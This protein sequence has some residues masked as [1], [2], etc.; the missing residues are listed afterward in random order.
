MGWHHQLV[1][2]LKQK[3]L[4]KITEYH[5]PFLPSSL[6]F[7]TS[8][9]TTWRV[10]PPSRK[11]CSSLLA[12]PGGPSIQVLSCDSNF[13]IGD[14]ECEVLGTRR[15]FGPGKAPEN[16]LDVKKTW[17][18]HTFIAISR[19]LWQNMTTW[20]SHIQPPVGP[21]PQGFAI[22]GSS[23]RPVRNRTGDG[24]RIYDYYDT[25]G[26]R[27]HRDGYVL[28][29]G[30]Q[31]PWRSVI[32]YVGDPTTKL[33]QPSLKQH[34]PWKSQWLESDLFWG[35]KALFFPRSASVKQT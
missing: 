12:P 28:Y 25:S 33:I 18:K 34:S 9:A 16:R 14:L 27:T 31:P 4:G 20:L 29:W 11:S 13:I 3:T 6:Q 7:S 17:W 32:F 26:D 22:F 23:S 30:I 19:R 24:G 8:K 2:T 10:K 5:R 21:L 1:C 35:G 15:V